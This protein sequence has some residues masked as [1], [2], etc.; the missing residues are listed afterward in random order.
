MGNVSSRL[1]ADLLVLCAAA[2]VKQDFF[3]APCASSTLN[4]IGVV[5]STPG[6]LCYG[7]GG[8]SSRLG[9]SLWADS[10][11]SVVWCPDGKGA[12]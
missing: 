2:S 9:V 11:I 5:V 8:L 3:E 1:P 4:V 6:S 7:K 10:G 12:V